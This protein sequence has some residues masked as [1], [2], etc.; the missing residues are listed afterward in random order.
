MNLVLL[1]NLFANAELFLSAFQSAGTLAEKLFPNATGGIES[2]EKVAAK[3]QLAAT[4][5][6]TVVPGL[7]AGVPDEHLAAFNAAMPQIAGALGV[8]KALYADAASVV[9]TADTGVAP[10]SAA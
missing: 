1:T 5:V 3:A 8:A 10:G 4:L 6:H 2:A 9:K 7:A